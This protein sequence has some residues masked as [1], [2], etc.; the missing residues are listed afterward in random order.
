MLAL[1]TSSVAEAQVVPAVDWSKKSLFLIG[2]RS[3][4]PGVIIFAFPGKVKD[5]KFKVS[6]FTPVRANQPSSDG[7]F[8]GVAKGDE[9]IGINSIELPSESV[10]AAHSLELCDGRPM[11]VFTAQP[12]SI[13]YVAD[14][15]IQA[16]DANDGRGGK[17]ISYGTD[18]DI[19]AARA[20]VQRH[21]PGEMSR[22]VVAPPLHLPTAG[23]CHD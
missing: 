21:Y 23:K 11:P 4:V 10:S 6:M 1:L 9:A 2:D 19:E 5:D 17:F 15:Y 14:L 22:F 18:Q 3:S 13:I 16:K 7:Y 20:W 12:G 8:V